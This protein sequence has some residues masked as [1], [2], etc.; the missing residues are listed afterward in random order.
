[1][2]QISQTKIKIFYVNNTITE[3]IIKLWAH[4]CK[5]VFEDRFINDDDINT[6]KLYLKE[7]HVKTIGEIDEKDSPFEEPVLF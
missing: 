3:K 4:E 1:M 7:A 5:R 2:W 6:F